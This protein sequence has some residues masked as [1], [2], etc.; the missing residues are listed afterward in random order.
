MT[1]NPTLDYYVSLSA[2][3]GC[4]AFLTWF[5]TFL[6]MEARQQA[7]NVWEAEAE[8]AR[9]PLFRALK[10]LA[11]VFG[12]VFN[13]AARRTEARVGN[14]PSKSFLLATRMR[15]QRQLL[16]AGNPEG[17]TPD[18]FLGLM[19]ISAMAGAGIGVFVWQR[20]G[21]P[22]LILAAVMLG[23]FLPSIWL[24]DRARRRQV[25]IQKALPFALDL[26]TLAV[27]AGL[28]FT[29]AVERIVDKL[30][31]SALAFELGIMLREVQLGKQRAEA[32][33]DLGRRVS[34]AEMTSVTSALIQADQLGAPL[35]P[36][37][38]V[39][40]E[41][42]RNSRSQRAEKLA[43]EAPVKILAPLIAFIFP[44]TFIILA[45]PIV[46]K[47]LIPMFSG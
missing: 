14:D 16:A 18:E 4:A 25:Q 9:S 15:L 44:N 31:G 40:S 6:I 30:R 21:M 2:A 8:S 34:V 10:P 3:G 11:R 19:V 1:S 41:Q 35:G 33:R 12:T 7:Q 27:E 26:L 36:I 38:R 24:N 45:G 37:L 22:V 43:M 23:F 46:L 17:L 28:D 13:S 5:L 32:L 20:F 42:L 47:Y 29:T 39:Q